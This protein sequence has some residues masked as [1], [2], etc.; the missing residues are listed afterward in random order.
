MVGRK[1]EDLVRSLIGSSAGGDVRVD[2]TVAFFRSAAAIDYAGALLKQFDRQQLHQVFREL[3]RALPG[4]N[5]HVFGT[6]N[7]RHLAL[8]AESLGAELSTNRFEGKEGRALRG[9]YVDRGRRNRP[10]ICVNTANHPVAVAAAF[11][12]EVGH[13]LTRRLLDHHDH[14]PN[15]PFSTNYQDHLDSPEELLADVVLVLG[16]YPHSAAKRLFG[17]AGENSH[18]LDADSLLLKARPYVR[19]AAGFDFES[20]FSVRENLHYLAGIIHVIKLRAALFDEYGI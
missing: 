9:F 4:L 5:R 18:R 3:Q 16:G 1:L 14:R 13:H 17:Q 12:H 10:L 15:L 20:R 11:W 8:E 19:S 6:T 2:S 7:L